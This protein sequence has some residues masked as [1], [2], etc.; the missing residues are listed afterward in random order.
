MAG[1]GQWTL[2]TSDH[3]SIENIVAIWTEVGC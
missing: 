1:L 3:T 2:F